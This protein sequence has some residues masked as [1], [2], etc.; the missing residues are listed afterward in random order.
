MPTLEQLTKT[1]QGYQLLFRR[2]SFKDA[3]QIHNEMIA[4]FGALKRPN[5]AQLLL[6]QAYK[7]SRIALKL[8]HQQPLD[9]AE[10]EDT[11]LLDCAYLVLTR[12]IL[13]FED[14]IINKGENDTERLSFY[15][16]DDA[17]RD[18]V[19]TLI[20][21]ALAINNSLE[22][23][24]RAETVEELETP[25]YLLSKFITKTQNNLGVL[26]NI[27]LLYSPDYIF[28]FVKELEQ[29]QEYYT[30]LA[31]KTHQMVKLDSLHAAIQW[32][33]D[34][35]C[36]RD[37]EFK[38]IDSRVRGL[39]RTKQEAIFK[40][41]A[42][43]WKITLAKALNVR[44]EKREEQKAERKKQEEEEKKKQTEEVSN[45]DQKTDI[46]REIKTSDI[47]KEESRSPTLSAAANISSLQQQNLFA[48]VKQ[49]M[50]KTIEGFK[51]SLTET[52]TKDHAAFA[53]A[54]A[55]HGVAIDVFAPNSLQAQAYEQ[56]RE[57][58]Y[59]SLIAKKIISARE[60]KIT[61]EEKDS[62]T[63]CLWRE[64]I[65][66]IIAPHLAKNPD[67]SVQQEFSKLDDFINR[68]YEIIPVTLKNSLREAKDSK[69]KLSAEKII[70]EKIRQ[71]LLDS[72]LW[73]EDVKFAPT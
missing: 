31:Q 18:R 27:F 47:Q 56:I 3:L 19:R 68:V 58:I 22:D 54:L 39:E 69:L 6:L 15:D 2:H 34:I 11:K 35:E 26:T 13:G 52:E 48:N 38:H 8:R 1:A 14:A 25:S 9:A 29:L 71:V 60:E 46:K 73:C 63:E 49:V 57:E 66:K 40:H 37:N 72:K 10:E 20:V 16:L 61:K 50:L 51:D 45:K 7:V 65:K 36:Y 24:K 64:I 12:E 32:A 4:K 62:A 17:T 5:D 21:Q 30:S 33:K 70:K 44:P 55:K 67:W 28:D 53:T 59:A 42:N 23:E 43:L 41:T